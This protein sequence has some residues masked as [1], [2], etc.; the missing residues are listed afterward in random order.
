M[1][2][3]LSLFSVPA[4]VTNLQIRVN[5]SSAL[6][7][8]SQPDITNGIITRYEIRYAKIPQEAL[9]SS[10]EETIVL[11]EELERSVFEVAITGLEAF[12]RYYIS[13]LA[14]TRVGLGS[15]VIQAVKTHPGTSSPPTNVSAVVVSFSSVVIPGAVNLSYHA[16][17]VSWNYPTTL[18]G[19]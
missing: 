6:V 1:I 16:I 8:F 12:T 13:V 4:Q 3:L 19:K 9:P 2:P 7:N 14:A 11:T 10:D 17:Y 15:P 18:E 5:S